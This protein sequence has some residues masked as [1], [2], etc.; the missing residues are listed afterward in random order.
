MAL[1]SN[2]ETVLSELSSTDCP[3]CTQVVAGDS[4]VVLQIP[5]ELLYKLALVPVILVLLISMTQPTH[6]QAKT[7]SASLSNLSISRI[8]PSL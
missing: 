8:T 7:Q 6:L 5:T 3:N 2:K 1:Q 4:L